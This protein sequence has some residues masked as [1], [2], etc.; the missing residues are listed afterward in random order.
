M[1]ADP[2]DLGSNLGL[3]S[4]IYKPCDQSNFPSWCLII[5]ACSVGIMTA[6]IPGDGHQG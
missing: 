4:A 6:A 5:L 1:A 2:L 3:G